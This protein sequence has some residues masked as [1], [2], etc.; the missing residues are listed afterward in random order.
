LASAKAD[1]FRLRELDGEETEEICKVLKIS[2]TNY[3]VLMHR[4]RLSMRRC[5]E[6]HWPQEFL[7][8]TGK[9][10]SNEE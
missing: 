6:L 4:A 10:Q 9:I 7:R 8:R 2:S 1:A 3:W 5:M